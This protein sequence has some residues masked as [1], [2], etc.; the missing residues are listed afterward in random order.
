MVA[1]SCGAVTIVQPLS[2]NTDSEAIISIT[3]MIAFDALVIMGSI[4]YLYHFT[5]S[6]AT[7]LF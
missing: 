1:E 3:G 5:R 6:T 4:Y 7:I 2:S